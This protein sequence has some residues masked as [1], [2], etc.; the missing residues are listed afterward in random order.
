MNAQ[1]RKGRNRYSDNEIRAIRSAIS[2]LRATA[3]S[4]EE[5][6]RIRGQLRKEYGFYISDFVH[7]SAGG[8]T[9]SDFDELVAKGVIR[10]H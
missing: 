9:V 1:K 5:R 2:R 10:R 7:P 3:C 6:K 4:L 8:I